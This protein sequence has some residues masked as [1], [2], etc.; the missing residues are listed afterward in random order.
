MN[1]NTEPFEQIRIYSQE[2]AKVLALYYDEL[3][4]GG[5]SQELA[6]ELVLDFSRR[7]LGQNQE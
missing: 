4:D 1:T 5:I 3:I 7:M 6:Q 2:V